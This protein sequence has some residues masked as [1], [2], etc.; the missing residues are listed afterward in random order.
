MSDTD[1]VVAMVTF[2]KHETSLRLDTVRTCSQI[3]QLSTWRARPPGE[4]ST[5]QLLNNL[6]VV[7]AAYDLSGLT[8][9]RDAVIEPLAYLRDLLCLIPSRP[10][11]RPL[12]LAPRLLEADPRAVLSC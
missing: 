12:E 6:V 9:Y 11:H 2:P 1:C 7:G 4:R 5:S 10:R 8:E 3:T